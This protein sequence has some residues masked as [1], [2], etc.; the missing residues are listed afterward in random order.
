MLSSSGWSP[1]AVEMLYASRAAQWADE[2]LAELNEFRH[3]L[4]E[5]GAAWAIRLSLPE[6]LMQME[7]PETSH[8]AYE[9]ES[10]PP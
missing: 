1:G 9:E 2:L 3:Q 6:E 4:R 7:M 5:G 8:N 10:T